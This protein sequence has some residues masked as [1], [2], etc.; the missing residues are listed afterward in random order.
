M[1][2]LP[3]RTERETELAAALA[4]LLSSFRAD[5]ERGAADW[6]AFSSGVAATLQRSLSATYQAAANALAVK[7]SGAEPTEAADRAA[8]YA[9]AAAATIAR[10]LSANLRDGLQAAA[11]RGGDIAP[12]FTESRAQAI[13]VTEITRAT[14]EGEAFAAAVVASVTRS[15][16][17]WRWRTQEDDAVCP[18]CGPLN[19]RRE[20]DVEPPAHPNCRC[21]MEWTFEPTSALGPVLAGI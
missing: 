2:N 12:L 5:V 1:P 17:T 15:L 21:E 7:H 13:A 8:G 19:G 3:D 18:T 14:S 9:A 16:A 20:P 10:D 6:Y 4:A 11:E